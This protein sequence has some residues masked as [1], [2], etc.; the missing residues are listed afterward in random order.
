VGAF[1]IVEKHLFL[2]APPVHSLNDGGAC[3]GGYGCAVTRLP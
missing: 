3:Q 2:I 1:A